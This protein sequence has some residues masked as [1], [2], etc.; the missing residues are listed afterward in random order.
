[1]VAREI[2]DILEAHNPSI[3]E[4]VKAS[5]LPQLRTAIREEVTT[6]LGGLLEQS[7]ET[8]KRPMPTAV[9]HLGNSA[10]G[11]P[12]SPMGLYLYAIAD[13][14]EAMDLGGIGI[15]GNKVYT[16]PFGDLSA[17]V[18]EGAAEPYQSDDRDAVEKWVLTHQKVVDAAWEKFGAVI[19]MGFDTIICGRGGCSPRREYAEMDRNR[20]RQSGIENGEGSKQSGIRRSDFL[21]H[22]GHGPRCDRKKR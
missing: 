5:L 20:Y 16:M 6:V 18:H 2:K 13:G 7:T 15:E 17:V 19:P 3:K 22:P 9:P 21:G 12:Q 8:R 14:G 1:M 4:M 10:I 11:N